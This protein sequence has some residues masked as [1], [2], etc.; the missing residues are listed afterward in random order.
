MAGTTEKI[1]SIRIEMSAAQQSLDTANKSLAD[2]KTAAAAANTEARESKEIY[3]QN[4][5]ALRELVSQQKALEAA[6]KGAAAG[7]PYLLA[8]AALDKNA[9]AQ[10]QLNQIVQESKVVYNDAKAAAA[11]AGAAVGQQAGT[12]KQLTGTVKE[13]SAASKAAGQ[14]A[15]QDFA[16]G[17]YGAID[18]EMKQLREDLRSL[19]PGSEEAD[20]AI[21]K[22]ASN[23]SELRKMGLAVNSLSPR[24]QARAFTALTGALT[25]VVAVSIAAMQAWGLSDATAQRYAQTMQTVTTVL[26]SVES[27]NRVLN[28][29]NIS[30][31]SSIWSGAKAWLGFGAAA[32]VGG[33]AATTAGRATKVAIAGTGIGLLVLALGAVISL[34][35]DLGS[36]VKGSESTFTSYKA[37]VVGGFDAMIAGIKDFLKFFYQL[38]TLDFSG[39]IKTA[40]NAGKDVAGAYQDGRSGV[41]GEALRKESAAQAKQGE[42]LLKINQAAGVETVKLEREILVQKAAAQKKGTDEYKDAI[43][44]LAAFDKA[45]AKKRK[46][47]AEA[48]T[49]AR[50]NGVLGLEQAA[51]RQAYEAQLN[52]ETQKLAA[53]KAAAQPEKAAIEAQ[54]DAIAALTLAHLKEENEKQ[55]AARQAAIE[56][57]I[58]MEQAK[59]EDAFKQQKAKEES[60]LAHLLAA[61]TQDAAAIKSQS[62]KIDLLKETHDQEVEQ[63]RRAALV[64]ANQNKIAL[65]EKDGQD[66]IALRLENAELLLSLDKDT[67][68][69]ERTQ[70][71]ADY[72]A[73]LVLQAEYNAKVKAGLQANQAQR[74]EQEQ[75]G[76]EIDKKFIDA[77]LE[78]STQVY[79]DSLA[80][81][82]SDLGLK[83]IKAFFGLDGE[84]ADDL[85]KA[86]TE[87]FGQ[88][89]EASQ[90][91]AG[92]FLD[93]A[94]QATEKALADAQAR[95]QAATDQLSQLQSS[96][97]SDEGKLDSAKGA[98]R[99]YYL[100]KLQKERDEVTKVAAAKKKA[101]DE[102][103]KQLAEQHRLQKISAGLSA[104]ASLAANVAAAA[105]AV[106]AGVSAIAGAASIPFPFS[107]PAIIS[108][109]A[110]VAATVA[111]AKQ[112]ATA[113]KYADGTGA[114]GADGI[115]RGPRHAAGG[116]PFTVAGRPGFEAEG[117]EA[118][119]P[120]DAT[121]NNGPLLA[122]LRNQGRTRT[123]GLTDFMQLYGSAGQL[124]IKPP[125]AS[126]FEAGG[127]LNKGGVASGQASA[128]DVGALAARLDRNNELLAQLVGNT[129]SIAA[130][131]AATQG[132]AATTAATNQALVAFGPPVLEF[133]YDAERKRQELQTNLNT[134]ENTASL[135]SMTSTR[136]RQLGIGG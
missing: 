103:A 81:K 78:Y 115:L 89:Y 70:R 82:K 68:T 131:S 104:A 33:V 87:S 77:G 96:I 106:E 48:Q 6:K 17:T 91:V 47:E 7:E 72:Q 119:T 71:E 65:L 41:I 28:K 22:L 1:Y 75:Q 36:T 112:L 39:A 74:E 5:A 55:F 30:L 118:I 88:L 80:K 134:I 126:Y 127:V 40:R 93:A 102:E 23:E 76:R 79:T 99:D 45:Q 92:A 9:K 111:S 53:L 56:G 50:L 18:Q 26:F 64:L 94:T 61:G 114:V 19:V 4:A 57:R 117:G 43:S 73:L 116:I 108:A 35:L 54:Q 38:Y 84:R 44:E 13:Y 63:K 37:T 21:K 66:T 83:L 124:Q 95:L 11:A 69:K 32:E 2:F 133:G 58:A 25:G 136:K 31:I 24:T 121:Q 67:S 20:A 90:Q 110:T 34:F 14:A 107:L 60:Q 85:K 42:Q 129:G 3:Q 16:P 86:L 49:L 109:I 120:V 123:L 27:I 15:A 10:Q 62:D 12:V 97:T 135:G 100:Q 132:H 46:E 128:A 113:V 51:G 101:A 125:P 122:M 130:S 52:V 105:K 29:E 59:G 98:A 8:T